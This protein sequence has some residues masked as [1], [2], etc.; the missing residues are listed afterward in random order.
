MRASQ[1]GRLL[2]EI[3]F[4]DFHQEREGRWFRS[5]QSAG[6][7]AAVP[8]S[9]CP[10]RFGTV[11]RLRHS[12]AK[13]NARSARCCRST[14]ASSRRPTGCDLAGSPGQAVRH[15]P[16][17]LRRTKA[18]ASAGIEIAH[19][20]YRRRMG[21]RITAARA[22]STAPEA[23]TG[24]IVLSKARWPCGSDRQARLPLIDRAVS[25]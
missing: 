16:R 22:L 9:G 5:R 8:P 15:H 7:T 18:A 1:I 3:G 20:F 11:E 23:P 19:F 17:R 24:I 21:N 4:T 6:R 12:T 10:F 2:F 25:P 13:R 14:P